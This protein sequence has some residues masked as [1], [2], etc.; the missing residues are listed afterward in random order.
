M[1]LTF[2]ESE[3]EHIISIASEETFDLNYI[4]KPVKTINHISPQPIYI[5]A[6]K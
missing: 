5:E 4:V 1:I 6:S 3:F 2:N